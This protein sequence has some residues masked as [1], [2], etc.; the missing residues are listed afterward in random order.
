MNTRIS[1]VLTASLSDWNDWRWQMRQKPACSDLEQLATL[2]LVAPDA[3]QPRRRVGLTPYNVKLLFNLRSTDPEGYRA[4]TLQSF[5]PQASGVKQHQW[6]WAKRHDLFWSKVM[7]H[8]PI[9]AFIRTLFTGRGSDTETRA[10]ENIYPKTDVVIATAVCARH[11]SFC[12]REVGDVQGEASRMTGGID[13]VMNAVQQVIARK[14]PHVLVTGGDPLTRNNQQLRQLLAPLVKS[15]T[16]Q[17]LRLATRLVVDLP[18]RFYDEELLAMLKEFAEL[19]KQRHASFR[20]V[21]HVNHVCELTPEA[22]K[23]LENIQACGVEV[24]N[25][26]AVLHGVNDDVESLRTLLMTLDRLGVRNYKLFHSMPIEGTEHLRVPFLEFRKLVAG[27]HQW[28]PGTSVP[29]A[30]LVTLV[31]KMPV[32]PSGRWTVPVPFTNRILCRSFRGEWY[33]FKDAWNI[34]RHLREAGVSLVLAVMLMALIFSPRQATPIVQ[35]QQEQ[36]Q[37]VARVAVLANEMEYP[38]AWARQH[39]VPF[40]QNNTLYLPLQGL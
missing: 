27:L 6:V 9:P 13:A 21:T 4:E 40:V 3:K 17:V 25:Q 31:G 33:L 24:M 11:C 16:V 26:T 36:L 34:R 12:F 1:E 8:L 14:T 30:N 18:M 5:P 19:M 28:L 2:G 38:D 29:Q 37:T 35:H 15:E 32:S 39:F 7:S 10:M 23:A 22:I 20:I